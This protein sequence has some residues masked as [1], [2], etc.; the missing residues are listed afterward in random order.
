[1]VC[2]LSADANANSSFA[3]VMRPGDRGLF[4]LAIAT[5][6]GVS[7]GVLFSQ[8]RVDCHAIALSA[9]ALIFWGWA[10]YKVIAR[11]DE[12]LGVYSFALVLAAAAYSRY[13]MKAYAAK[14]T[15]LTRAWN[16][17]FMLTT[18]CAVCAA[19]YGYV[20]YVAPALT[21]RFQLYL[22]AGAGWWGIASVWTASALFSYVRTLRSSAVDFEAE[23]LVDS[24]QLTRFRTLLAQ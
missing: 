17:M 14:D 12:D 6:L 1:M 18:A 9:V 21:P 15:K 10:L 19:N 22:A 7:L 23:A 2:G 11:G 3:R 13:A 24:N 16:S 5:P 4:V 8:D 20:L